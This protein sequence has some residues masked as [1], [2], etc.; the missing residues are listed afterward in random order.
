[1]IDISIEGTEQILKMVLYVRRLSGLTPK[2]MKKALYAAG[3][4]VKTP[5]KK[6]ITKEYSVKATVVNKK[7]TITIPT[8]TEDEML[9]VVRGVPLI[10]SHNFL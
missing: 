7:S 10:L 4:A 1:M 5:I 3:R 2:V 6:A 8:L 9:I